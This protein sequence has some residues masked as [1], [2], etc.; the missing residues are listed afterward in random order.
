MNIIKKPLNI[1]VA[2]SAGFCF[3]VKRACE[4][5]YDLLPNNNIYLL[6][7]LIHNDSVMNEML[8]KG[9]KI[10]EKV[11]DIKKNATAVI[12]AHGVSQTTIL[13]LEENKIKYSDQTCPYVKKIHSIVSEEQKKG[14]QVIIFGKETHPEVIG[15]AGWCENA[16]ITMDFSKIQHLI[17]KNSKIS[18]VAQTTVEKEKFNSFI[19]LLK[20]ASDEVLVF[21]T[22]CQATKTRQDEALKLAS[23][24]DLM[25]V[26]GGKK[27]SNTI[28]LY[29]KAKA[30]NKNTYLIENEKD[31]IINE[32]RYQNKLKNILYTKINDVGVTAGASTPSSSIE[33]V[34]AVMFDENNFTN[35]E[36]EK[37]LE[38]YLVSP[39]HT[40]RTVTGTVEQITETEVRIN[41]PGYKGV[42]IIPADE[43]SDDSSVNPIDLIKIGDEITAVVTKPNDLEGFCL[44]SKKR[45]DEKVNMS[46]IREAFENDTIL[47]GRVV[48][49]IKG[50]LLVS[51]N[52]ARIFV[53][54][55][56]ASLRFVKDL[57]SLNNTAV[58][59]KVIEFDERKN[60]A[61]GSIK[62]VL[63]T[64]Q[65]V[66]QDAFWETVQEGQEFKG[67]VK[68]LTNFGAFV[69][70]GGIDGL[71][72]IT[73]L[74]WGR[75]KH[76]SDILK[77]DQEIDVYIKSLDKEKKKISLGYKKDS[78]NP[79]ADFE[80]KINLNDVVECKIV[81]IV[82]F[83][84]FAEIIP[85]MDGL[86]HISQISNKHISKVEEELSL[87]MVVSAKVI[88]I[89]PETKKI[90][91]SIRELLEPEERKEATSETEE[92]VEE[93]AAEVV[94]AVEE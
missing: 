20:K 58:R 66:I 32:I 74:S 30:V 53:P 11:S 12:R 3:G 90:S 73:E 87:G 39:V 41:I 50:G 93:N 31:P 33:E 82:P 68:S 24:T 78:E 35:E 89:N 72:H 49:V 40:G 85:G 80:K 14:R 86:I 16:I 62:A 44:L 21:D 76:P 9:A 52:G 92:A 23:E 47:D 51:I 75:I 48:S 79:W 83:G 25:L 5:V 64:E 34:I 15:I 46:L 2:K 37:E 13:E 17:N 63:A 8:L 27:S 7:E 60:R 43:L 77:V 88:E 45:I 29:N 71:V 6:G 94:E 19:E 65:K 26:I 91:L 22:I 69:D 84:A 81:R 55:S 56:L 61:T 1:R 18:L 54:A 36:F 59:L 67:I 57:N 70:I 4:A 42:G 28:E 38:N 10:V